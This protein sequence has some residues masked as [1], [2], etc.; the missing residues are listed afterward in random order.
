MS[1]TGSNHSSGTS[2]VRR[3]AGV[4][5][6]TLP[7][8][9]MVFHNAKGVWHANCAVELVAEKYVDDATKQI[10]ESVIGFSLVNTVSDQG[11]LLATAPSWPFRQNR[12][13]FPLRCF[14]FLY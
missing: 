1:D 7:F 14:T 6:T 3:I 9:V 8:P 12:A 10:A 2:S 13:F 11:Q 5:R 4:A